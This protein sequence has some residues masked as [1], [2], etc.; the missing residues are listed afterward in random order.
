MPVVTEEWSKSGFTVQTITIKEMKCY[1]FIKPY[2]QLRM[3]FALPR[4]DSDV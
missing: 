1:P 4:M 2:L 3:P